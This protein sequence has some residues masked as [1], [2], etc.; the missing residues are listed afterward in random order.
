M[1]SF[2]SEILNDILTAHDSFEE[3]VFILPSQRAG[4][5]LR[6]ELKKKLTQGFLPQIVTIEHFIENISGIQKGDTIQLLFYF[7]KIYCEIEK[8]PDSF[9]IFSSWASVVLQDFSE[10]DQYLVNSKDIFTYLRDIQRLRKWSVKGE[11]KET[12]LIKDHFIF[13]ERLAHYYD[14]YYEYLLQLKTGY[15]GL[16][17]REATKKTTSFLSRHTTTQFIFIGFNAL[18]KAEELLIETFLNAGSAT[19]YWDIDRSFF[20]SNHL[21]GRFVR[22]YTTRWKYYEKRDVKLMSSHFDTPKNIQVIGVAKHILQLKYAGEILESFN[23]YQDTALVLGDESLLSV[24]L[25]SI[26]DKVDALNITMGYPLKSIPTANFITSVFQLFINQEKLQKKSTNEF[27]YKD[28]LRWIKNPLIFQFLPK[29]Y[30]GFIS[31]VQKIISR[32]NTSFISLEDLTRFLSPLDETIRVSLLT[33]FQPYIGIENFIDRII[34][35]IEQS[36]DGVSSLEKEYLFR[37]HTAFTQL[38]TLNS[39]Y[40]YFQNIKTLYTFY[41]RIVTSEKLSFRGEPLKGLQ[42]MGMLETRV[43]DFKNVIITSVNEGV[44]PSGSRQNTFI[45]FD[46]KVQF[47]LPTYRERDAIFSYHFFRLLQ[48][49]ENIFLIYNTENDDYGNGEKSRFITQLE[50]LRNDIQQR[51]ITQK[52]TTEIR[53]LGDI[54]KHPNVIEKLHHYAQKGISPSAIARYLYSP[55]EFYKERVLGLKQVE[56]VEETI[57]ANTLGTIVHDTLDELYTPLK[58]RFLST[59][60]LSEMKTKTESLVTK[61]V[62]KHFK[63]GNYHL[64]MNR[65]V[66]EVAQNYVHR[67]LDLEIDLLK[68]GNQIKI[69]ATEQH[70]KTSIQVQGVDFPVVIKGIVDRID[71]YNG[72]TRVVDYKTGLVALKQLKISNLDEIQDYQF[73]KAIQLLMYSHLYMSQSSDNTKTIEAGIY[74]FRNLKDGFIRVNFSEKRGGYDH[75]IT[76]ERLKKAIESVGTIISE[77][78]NSSISFKEPRELPY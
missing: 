16:L 51:S 70:L 19:I 8:N 77:I 32:E 4:I 50:L 46:V 52:V 69:L 43:L 75:H 2:I 45:P 12:T 56:E 33:I 21:A 76:P 30:E 54:Q 64:G 57:A 9:D 3:C 11:F 61:Y 47:G 34:L 44:I 65:L 78:F 49:A 31:G 60:L 24:A 5:F 74:S 23:E 66:F 29:K 62:I 26:P 36:R 72:T 35:L 38:K 27:Y 13:M 1:K 20:E 37:F 25:N 22:D 59:V 71:E 40:G 68:K 17:Y 18:N 48:R 58:D 6:N 28:V 73:E 55:I 53:K 7:Y 67:F 39:R 41:K 42:I 14:R 15:Q 63:N 10:V